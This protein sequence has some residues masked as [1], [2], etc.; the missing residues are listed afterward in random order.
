MTTYMENGQTK[1]WATKAG[2]TRKI[3]TLETDTFWVQAWEHGKGWYLEDLNQIEV[4]A[5]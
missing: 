1:Y 5:K 4:F 3:N 2:A